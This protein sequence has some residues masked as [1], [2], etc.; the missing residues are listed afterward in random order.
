MLGYLKRGIDH[1][2]RVPLPGR[3]LPSKPRNV[4]TYRRN[5][6]SENQYA[7]FD[8]A[9]ADLSKAAIWDTYLNSSI[10][11]PISA[12]ATNR[13]KT[14]AKALDQGLDSEW[15]SYQLQ[16]Q[17]KELMEMPE[18]SRFEVEAYMDELAPSAMHPSAELIASLMEVCIRFELFEKAASYFAWGRDCGILPSAT[19]LLS[20]LKKTKSLEGWQHIHARLRKDLATYYPAY[21]EHKEKMFQMEATGS[22]VVST[23]L[24]SSSP[25]HTPVLDYSSMT[26]D[27]LNKQALSEPGSVDWVNFVCDPIATSQS[28]S[29]VVPLAVSPGMMESLLVRDTVKQE[30]RTSLKKHVG[31]LE[32]DRSRRVRDEVRGLT[33]QGLISL[34]IEDNVVLRCVLEELVAR[35]QANKAMK[36]LER[37]VHNAQYPLSHEPFLVMATQMKDG[38]SA[39][40]VL[41][42][43]EL[44]M[45]QRIDP[46]ILLLN[47]LL[48]VHLKL[49]QLLEA[50]QLWKQLK[51]FRVQPNASTI[52][53]MI[54]CLILGREEHRFLPLSLSELLRAAQH[55]AIP[56]GDATYTP[57][58]HYSV[59]TK[60]FVFAKL[61]FARIRS[62]NVQCISLM[63][64]VSC[65]LQEAQAFADFYYHLERHHPT[66]IGFPQLRMAMKM[67][68]R[69]L[70][71][72]HFLAALRHQMTRHRFRPSLAH[73][74]SFIGAALHHGFIRTALELELL[75]NEFL[76]ELPVPISYFLPYEHCTHLQQLNPPMPL[77]LKDQHRSLRRKWDPAPPVD[78]K[79]LQDWLNIVQEWLQNSETLN[80]VEETAREHAQAENKASTIPP[81]FVP[82]RKRYLR[83]KPKD[84][85]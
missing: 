42:L 3:K 62:P 41:T 24:D 48:E 67:H 52:T 80:Q 78:P 12:E 22:P 27:H 81:R 83:F 85:L 57:L 54:N 43:L 5:L 36:I 79:I 46:D 53:I 72:D 56:L 40:G 6:R 23:S 37:E 64:H 69:A 76:G 16:Q 8:K 51:I 63:L 11:S 13:D 47:T 34:N 15:K 18:S 7:K 38:K 70:Q 71:P 14:V 9:Q 1:S 33:D 26:S 19:P 44:M 75:R 45:Q 4:H 31:F 73:M 61:V 60:N 77:D 20:L 25:H 32:G 49:G 17:L 74:K 21:V 66:H 29:V 55:A 50:V 35:Q 30:A 82:G 10:L 39:K 2:L 68:F 58:L 28:S 59:L 65:S 84:Q